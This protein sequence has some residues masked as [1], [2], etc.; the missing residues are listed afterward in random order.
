MV[1]VI[2]FIVSNDSDISWSVCFNVV[3]LYNMLKPASQVTIHVSCKENQTSG[4]SFKSLTWFASMCQKTTYSFFARDGTF[5]V[6]QIHGSIRIFSGHSNKTLRCEHEQKLIRITEWKQLS[7]RKDDHGG[8]YKRMV[9][10]PGFALLGQS[11]KS[12]TRHCCSSTPPC[13]TKRTAHMKY[14][15]S[16]EHRPITWLKLFRW[17]ILTHFQTMRDITHIDTGV[18]MGPR[19]G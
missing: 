6:H 3:W 5:P 12:D 7:V 8:A 4:T 10:S 1:F 2:L 13:G 17:K 15:L 16:D 14:W 11:A 18:I 19:N 9:F